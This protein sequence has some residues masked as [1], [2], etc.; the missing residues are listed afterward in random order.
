MKDTLVIMMEQS[1]AIIHSMHYI[2]KKKKHVEISMKL[3]RKHMKNILL[4]LVLLMGKH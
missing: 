1:R 2:K 4:D 3:V